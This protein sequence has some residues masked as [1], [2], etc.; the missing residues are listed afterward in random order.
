MTA[1][2][3]A[4][5]DW[6][7]TTVPALYDVRVGHTRSWPLRNR[8]E[9]GGY[10][11]LVDLDDLPRLPRGLRWA[12]RFEAADH[13]GDPA[14]SLKDNVV[15]FAALH[16][17]DDV[18]RVVMMANARNGPHVFNPLSTHWC[19]RADGSLACI[20]AEV[21]NTYGE[22]HAYLLDPDD[23]GRA[24][25]DQ[26]EAELEFAD[27]RVNPHGRL[28]WRLA[29]CRP[30]S[31]LGA[32]ARDPSKSFSSFS[33]RRSTGSKEKARKIL[34]LH[35]IDSCCHVVPSVPLYIVSGLLTHRQKKNSDLS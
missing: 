5:V 6:A 19:Y 13:L 2:R 31:Y 24:Q 33:N 21:H 29:C 11:W 14:A 35:T 25:A 4:L 27:K 9:Y 7:P 1:V 32:C 30:D 15:R 34:H 3:P 26:R 23:A 16:G 17:V 22:R 20:V 18:A 8:F 12:A 10:L 28:G